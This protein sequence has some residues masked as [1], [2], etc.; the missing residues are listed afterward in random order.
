MIDEEKLAKK[1]K[2]EQSPALIDLDDSLINLGE[3]L[4]PVLFGRK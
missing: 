2:I 4:W 3:T 1:M